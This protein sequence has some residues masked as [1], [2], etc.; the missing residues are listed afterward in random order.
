MKT[1]LKTIAL[2][3]TGFALASCCGFDNNYSKG[4]KKIEETKTTYVDKIVTVNPG[5]KG[6]MPYTKTVRVPVTTTVFT[7]K[8][9]KC[10]SSYNP[11][12]DCCGTLSKEVTSRATTQGATGEPFLGLIPTMKTLV[13]V[14]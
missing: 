1:A 6:S 10:T 7:K 12:P 8:K 4:S 14:E 13:S 11:R 5:G 9:C 3:V 2:I